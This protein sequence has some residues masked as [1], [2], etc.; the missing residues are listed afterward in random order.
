M[1]DR[2]YQRYLLEK[3]NDEYPDFYPEMF[4]PEDLKSRQSINLHYLEE[5]GLVEIE[6]RR[7]E[8]LTHTAPQITARYI[9][10]PITGRAKI[11][12]KGRDFLENDGGLSAVLGTVTVRIHADTIRDLVD[13]K[14][15][16][17]SSIPEE[18]KPALRA[19]LKSMKEEGL[20]QMT[21]RLISLGFDKG[22]L[23]LQQLKELI[24]FDGS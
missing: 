1:N 20:K 13:A 9:K 24:P 8:Y 10:S 14:I 12:A 16:E 7:K 19:A 5:H 4:N 17:S 2:E 22:A 21:T 23:T 11:T 15:I 3:L 18:E 6:R